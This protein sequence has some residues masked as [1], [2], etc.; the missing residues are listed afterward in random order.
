MLKISRRSSCQKASDGTDG[1]HIGGAKGR[2]L[3]D[4]IR[5]A[6]SGAVHI[7]H[8]GDAQQMRAS[9]RIRTARVRASIRAAKEPKTG[10]NQ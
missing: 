4:H 9:T 2:A 7:R 6:T 1:A 10:G 3:A 8:L 5:L